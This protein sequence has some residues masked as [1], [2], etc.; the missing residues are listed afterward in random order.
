MCCLSSARQRVRLLCG[1]F[2]SSTVSIVAYVLALS[3]PISLQP[4]SSSAHPNIVE[5]RCRPTCI[6]VEGSALLPIS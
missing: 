5:S 2:V 6:Y 1:V 3:P 4:S